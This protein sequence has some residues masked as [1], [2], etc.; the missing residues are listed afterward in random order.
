[1]ERLKRLAVVLATGFYLSYIP[2]RL[3]GL[4]PWARDLERPDRRWTGAG[5]IGT[6]LGLAAMPLFPEKPW[7]YMAALLTGILAACW[8]SG[9]AEQVLGQKD[10]SRIII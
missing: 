1:M 9:I 7:P 3:V 4:L 8:A 5:F 10:D 6:L 2:V